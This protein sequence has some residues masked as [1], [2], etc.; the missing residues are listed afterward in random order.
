MSFTLFLP[1]ATYFG[2][3]SEFI[4]KGIG[5][6]DTTDPALPVATSVPV[7]YLT[8]LLALA[9]LLPLVIIFLFKK[10]FL[11]VR[12]CFTEVV[13]LLGA[14]GFIA[15]YI[16]NMYKSFDVASWKFGVPSVFPILA[17][18]FVVLAIRAIIHDHNLIKSL[19]RIR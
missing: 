18:I 4:L 10:R 9:T 12:L 8:I 5:V 1:L 11:Q 7:V 16:Y 14:Q 13:L 6:I 3:G 2:H 17:L 15:Y 19:D